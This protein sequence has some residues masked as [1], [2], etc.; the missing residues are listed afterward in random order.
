MCK[1]LFQ[2]LFGGGQK[3]PAAVANPAV[4]QPV[5]GAGSSAAVMNP[6]VVSDTSNGRVKL[7]STASKRGLVFNG[8]SLCCERQGS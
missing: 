1:N 4:S 6:D 7:G 5:S 2:G 8:R 3:T